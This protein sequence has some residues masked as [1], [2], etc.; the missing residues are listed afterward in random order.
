[1]PGMVVVEIIS[2]LPAHAPRTESVHEVTVWR[3][4]TGSKVV[5]ASDTV[6]V[7]DST[8]LRSLWV[9]VGVVTHCAIGRT[10]GRERQEAVQS[11]R[12]RKTP[13]AGYIIQLHRLP[14]PFH[15]RAMYPQK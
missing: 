12:E 3:D 15:R 10:K 1:M 13:E 8:V 7:S 14:H 6:V 5:V 4:V 2:V 11:D 9:A